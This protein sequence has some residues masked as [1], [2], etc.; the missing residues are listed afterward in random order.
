VFLGTAASHKESQ[1]RSV[2]KSIPCLNGA[3]SSQ[4]ERKAFD[5]P[6]GRG[7]GGGGALYRCH[8]APVV[9]LGF[10]SDD[11]SLVSLD[12]SGLLALWPQHA[13]DKCGFGWLKPRARWQLPHMQQT[14]QLR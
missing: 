9:F 7:G 8:S 14:C 3:A 11:A 10:L 2:S 13:A 5:S 6:P 1:R 4:R 12:S